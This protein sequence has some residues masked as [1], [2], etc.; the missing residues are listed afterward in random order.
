MKSFRRS[1]GSEAR[2]SQLARRAASVAAGIAA[3]LCAAS[4]DVPAAE[5]DAAAVERKPVYKDSR[6]FRLTPEEVIAAV[7]ESDPDGA[8]W[9]AQIGPCPL[10]GIIGRP[11]RFA[12]DDGRLL[13]PFRNY[14]VERRLDETHFSPFMRTGLLFDAPV[15]QIVDASD[16]SV[17][18][19]AD[20]PGEKHS[21]AFWLRSVLAPLVRRLDH[22]EAPWRLMRCP[23]SLELVTCSDDG[24]VRI[25][26]PVYMWRIARF[27]G[28]PPG[29]DTK[30]ARGEFIAFSTLG[31][32]L[33]TVCQNEISFRRPRDGVARIV[34]RPMLEESQHVMAIRFDTDGNNLLAFVQD[35][36]DDGGERT[37]L[38]RFNVDTQKEDHIEGT[39]AA[40]WGFSL[41]D[42]ETVV[43]FNGS[44][45]VAVWDLKKG[46]EAAQVRAAPEHVFDLQLA[47]SRDTVTSIGDDN[48]VKFWETSTWKQRE[49]KPAFKHE[50]AKVIQF[51]TDGKYLVSLSEDGWLKVWNAPDFCHDRHP[52]LVSTDL[53]ILPADVVHETYSDGMTREVYRDGTVKE[54]RPDGK[55]KVYNHKQQ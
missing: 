20:S 3:A 7:P 47:P 42:D 12:L 19:I 43:T 26:N 25:W 23:N 54:V 9:K 39:R 37:R 14:V 41:P 50:G 15:Q 46:E 32:W 29:D 55:V 10:G 17:C 48:V 31:S 18:T 8:Y 28:E 34:W 52:T 22:G 4:L 51:S 35:L 1:G 13:V 45:E 11:S 27:H 6:I 5:P 21:D 40:T 36:K 16:G 2:W 30:P 49:T 44:P 33:A 53:H 24:W 38:L